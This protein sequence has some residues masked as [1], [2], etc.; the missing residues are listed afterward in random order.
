MS[1]Q[2]N[3]SYSSDPLISNNPLRQ[4]IACRRLKPI[5]AFPLRGGK[6]SGPHSYCAPCWKLYQRAYRAKW[7]ATHP[8]YQANWYA[9][10]PGYEGRRAIE[11]QRRNETKH[12]AHIIISS[13][14]KGG[15]LISA[16]CL[17]CGAE[18][19]QAHHFDYNKPKEIMWLCFKH[20]CGWHRV[21]KTEDANE[22]E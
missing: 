14:I 12:A 7:K 19:T 11:W 20:H 13:L 1:S 18:K 17:I 10:N 2:Q 6:N 5:D 15:K 4:C 22:C 9:R 8:E 21:F 3:Q 16:P